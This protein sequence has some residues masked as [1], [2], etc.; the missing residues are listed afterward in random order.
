MAARWGW[1]RASIR[2]NPSSATSFT[3]APTTSYIVVCR[4]QLAMACSRGGDSPAAQEICE[5]GQGNTC[6]TFGAFVPTP[7]TILSF[8]HPHVVAS[9]PAPRRRCASRFF[10]S[11][12]AANTRRSAV[13]PASENQRA[14]FFSLLSL[15]VDTLEIRV[16]GIRRSI[17]ASHDSTA[18]FAAAVAIPKATRSTAAALGAVLSF[19]PC[20]PQVLLS[21][22]LGEF[23][24]IFK[25]LLQE[26]GIA[27]RYTYPTSPHI[28]AHVER[29][30]RTLPESLVTFPRAPFSPTSTPSTGSSPTGSPSTTPAAP[31]RL[32]NP[33][34]LQSLLEHH[35]GCQGWWTYTAPLT[36]APFFLASP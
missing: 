19:S 23:K 21:D 36:R 35:P 7:G 30:G 9:S 16:N 33:S 6:R 13:T 15:A 3:P 26:H 11:P 27:R 18:A 28:S 20:K 17:V 12:P 32:P 31:T 5:L 29:G 2:F 8:P 24:G 4:I 10:A 14:P 22:G 1:R 25:S 34:P